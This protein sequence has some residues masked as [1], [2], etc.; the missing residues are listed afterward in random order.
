VRVPG[1]MFEE[2]KFQGGL[3]TTEEFR[4]TQGGV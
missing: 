2:Q 1:T 3:A 4:K